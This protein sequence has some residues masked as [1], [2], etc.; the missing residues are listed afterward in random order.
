LVNQEAYTVAN[1]FVE[2]F[3]SV[4]GVPKQLHSDK[5]TNFASCI[6]MEI[7]EILGPEKTITTAFRP[8]SD[9]LAERGQRT[10]QFMLS[11]FV[12]TNQARTGT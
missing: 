4:C 12:T 6:L 9:G 10:I 7:C 5:G 8:E 1:S 2:M 11:K 3:F